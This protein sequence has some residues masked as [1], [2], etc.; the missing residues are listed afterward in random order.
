MF[1]TLEV[2]YS[3]LSYSVMYRDTVFTRMVFPEIY[4]DTIFM[5][6]TYLDMYHDIVSLP[7][8]PS[9]FCVSAVAR[10]LGVVW[11]FEHTCLS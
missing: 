7:V 9:V 1:H 8:F 4:R 10:F 6:E 11:S 5:I 2:S 3:S